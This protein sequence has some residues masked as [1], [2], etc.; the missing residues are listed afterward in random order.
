MH[1]NHQ[2]CRHNAFHQPDSRVNGHHEP[3]KRANREFGQSRGRGL[4]DHRQRA[5][6]D[7][8]PSRARCRGRHSPGRRSAAAKGTV[9]QWIDHETGKKG[10]IEYVAA[11]CQQAAIREE[12]RLN[13]QHRGERQKGARAPQENGQQHSPA[14][15]PARAGAGY[16]EI[17]HLRGKHKSAEASHQRGQAFFPG[18]MQSANRIGCRPRARAPHHPR[19]GKR[20]QRIR[21]VHWVISLLPGFVPAGFHMILRISGL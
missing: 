9:D 4:D 17:H 18:L 3:Q 7:P 2:T 6:Q 14:Q 5:Q 16:T 1:E 11:Q 10:H 21:H 19:H 8:R 15:M 13:Y 12:Q 20:N